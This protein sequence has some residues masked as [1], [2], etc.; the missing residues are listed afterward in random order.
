[1]H[2]SLCRRPAT[3]L[4]VTDHTA[5]NNVGPFSL[6]TLMARNN[7]VVGEVISWNLHS[8]I[9]AASL[10]SQINVGTRKFNSPLPWEGLQESHNGGHLNSPGRCSDLPV[11]IFRD[12][13]NNM[14]KDPDNSCLPR[15]Y[16]FWLIP[17]VKRQYFH[18]ALLSLVFLSQCPLSDSNRDFIVFETI[19][20]TG[21]GKGTYY[22]SAR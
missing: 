17:D 19:P 13:L 12:N 20:S 8:T 14:V 16:A 5:A 18:D 1:M 21:W 2:T 6:T 3:L 22:H 11:W 7:V 4:L 10:I 15:D 9:P